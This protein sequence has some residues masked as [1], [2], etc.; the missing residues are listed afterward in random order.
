MKT[1][2]EIH[3]SAERSTLDTEEEW[4]RINATVYQ[5]DDFSFSVRSHK[6][7]RAEE[8]A[9]QIVV[10][11][12]AAKSQALLVEALRAALPTC[13]H[14][15]DRDTGKQCRAIATWLAS[16]SSHYC[17]AHKREGNMLME[18]AAQGVA[19]LKAASGLTE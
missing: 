3:D 5:T 11:H 1:L 16:F 17:D 9:T 2:D 10:D 14:V 12:K 13:D 18:I 8:I 15:V 19:A 6:P 7:G 4:Q